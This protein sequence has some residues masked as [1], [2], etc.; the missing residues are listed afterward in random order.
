MLQS[1]RTNKGEQLSACYTAHHCWEKVCQAAVDRRLRNNVDFVLIEQWFC[2]NLQ[3][4]QRDDGTLS[5]YMSFVNLQ[6]VYNHVPQGDVAVEMSHQFVYSQ[7]ERCFC[8]F[9]SKLLLVFHEEPEDWA[10]EKL[11]PGLLYLAC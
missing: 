8:I 9:G 3:G 7:R 10:G 1:E 6:R 5:V 4:S 2:L 11:M